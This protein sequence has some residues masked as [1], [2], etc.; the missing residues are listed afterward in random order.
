M[1]SAASACYNCYQP[2]PCV[3]CYQ[4]QYVPPQYRTVDETVMV[5]PGS[6]VAHRTPAQYRTVMV[7]QTVMVA[8]EGVQYERIPPQYA[9]RQRVEMVSPGYSYYQPV[10]PRCASCGY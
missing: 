7:P 10:A 1:T 8:P 5:S 2:A 6:V 9:T 4:Q 3:T